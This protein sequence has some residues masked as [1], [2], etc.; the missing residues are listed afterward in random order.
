MN[1]I[2]IHSG[3]FGSPS[4]LFLVIRYTDCFIILLTIFHTLLELLFI[5]DNHKQVW[6]EAA[7]TRE[8]PISVPGDKAPVYHYHF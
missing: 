3:V 2:V 6:S 4:Y 8:S 5:Y 1:S 7:V